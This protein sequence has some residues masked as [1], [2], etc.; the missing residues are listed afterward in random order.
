MV[1]QSPTR[2]SDNILEDYFRNSRY[3]SQYVGTDLQNSGLNMAGRTFNTSVYDINLSTNARLLVRKSYSK[4]CL[5]F[6]YAENI[7]RLGTNRTNRDLRQSNIFCDP[8]ELK[9]PS[10]N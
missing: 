9:S 7:L 6:P 1:D 3:S 5:I 2:I 10:E 8:E 4:E